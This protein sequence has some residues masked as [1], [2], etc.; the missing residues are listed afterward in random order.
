MRRNIYKRILKDR[1]RYPE[2][3][4]GK[5]INTHLDKTLRKVVD[6]FERNQQP[7]RGERMQ[8]AMVTIDPMID[9]LDS[10]IQ[11]AKQARLGNLWKELQ[12]FTHHNSNPDVKGFNK[13][14]RELENIVFDLLAPIT[15]EDQKEIQTILSRPD[16]SESDVERML[17]LIERRGANSFF[18]FKQASE[19]ADATWLPFLEK[20]GYFAHPPSVHIINDDSVIFPFWWPI[21]YLAKISNKAAADEVVKLVL[22]LP[23]VNNP[24]VYDG[25]LDVA[26]QLHGEQSAKLKPKILESISIEYESPRNRYADLLEHWIKHDSTSAALELSRILVSFALIRSQRK[27][28]SVEKKIQ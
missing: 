6:Y 14:L 7:T 9:T 15:A 13:Y 3:W 5:Q 26:L 23:K 16:R 1:E 8:Q 22:Q 12:R 11:K 28:R 10:G 21:R 25:I 20:K 18:F 24:S 4:K 27:N 19:N 2:S 17:S